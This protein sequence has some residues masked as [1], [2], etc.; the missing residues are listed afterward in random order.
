MREDNSSRGCCFKV[1]GR[2][3]LSP[4]FN[5]QLPPTSITALLFGSLFDL[6]PVPLLLFIFHCSPSKTD[7]NPPGFT[8]SVSASGFFSTFLPGGN[9]NLQ[10]GVNEPLEIHICPQGTGQSPETCREEGGGSSDVTGTIGKAPD[11]VDLAL[12]MRLCLPFRS[13]Q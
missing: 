5:P 4:Q 6:V 3:K 12:R 9:T 13:P 10:C 2:A 8:L 11:S 1:S 7:L